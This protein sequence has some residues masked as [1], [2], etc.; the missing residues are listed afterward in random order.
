MNAEQQERADD[1]AP[2]S[3][4]GVG[5]LVPLQPF[6]PEGTYVSRQARGSSQ[7]GANWPCSS[8]RS[9][10]FIVASSAITAA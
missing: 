10:R 9:S 8:C 6:W 2:D 7:L 1:S 5:T 3:L 4:A